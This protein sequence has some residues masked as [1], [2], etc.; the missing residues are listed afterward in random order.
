MFR[1]DYFH[2]VLSK[3]FTLKY[4]YIHHN[5]T[6]LYQAFSFTI[7]CFHKKFETNTTMGGH[8]S[9]LLH[10]AKIKY[11]VALPELRSYTRSCKLGSFCCL[12]RNQLPNHTCLNRFYV[13]HC[14][15][16][17]GGLLFEAITEK[18]NIRLNSINE[19]NYQ[20]IKACL[21]FRSTQDKN[22]LTEVTLKWRF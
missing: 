7:T 21:K 17:Q 22:S 18:Q 15:L 1:C 10:Q 19:I 20:V 2:F 6:T 9:S 11:Q 3:S 12:P 4:I 16:Q 13:G 8:Q 5:I 14:I